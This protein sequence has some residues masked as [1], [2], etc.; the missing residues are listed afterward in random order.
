MAAE[1][2]IMYSPFPQLKKEA[3]ELNDL[4]EKVAKHIF[5]RSLQLKKN[6]SVLIETWDCNA[7]IAGAIELEGRL[8]GHSVLTIFNNS[9]TFVEFSKKMP[10]NKKVN[11]GKHELSL[12]R[13]TD[14]YVFIPGPELS[15]SSTSLD[16][17]KLRAATSYNM[18]WY[19]TA[20][21]SKL[22]GVRVT[23][24][25]FNSERA[26]ALLGKSREEVVDHLLNASL[27]EPA[28]LL[29]RAKGISKHIRT[30]GRIAVDSGDMGVTFKAGKEE[31][32]E[33]ARTDDSD[34]KR[35]SNMSALPGGEY[36]R[37]IIGATDGRIS[38]SSVTVGGRRYPGAELE[39]SGGKIVSYTADSWDDQERQNFDMYIRGKNNSLSYLAVG[40]N[41]RLKPGYGRDVDVS[42]TVSLW[43]GQAAY[44]IVKEPTLSVAG[45]MLVEGGNLKV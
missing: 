33:D 30:G 6:S 25:Y 14:G 28:V 29:K 20:A 7:D 42:G 18:E 16:L 15:F 21:E 3:I 40:L 26:A 12:L 19:R 8:R 1:R 4:K 9:E 32:I 11:L 45:K 10:K 39:F 44:G 36:Y 31:E 5:S 2:S 24:G 43:L 22:R 38:F 35:K 23:A 13:N 37:Q 41:S 34:V 27:E 17:E